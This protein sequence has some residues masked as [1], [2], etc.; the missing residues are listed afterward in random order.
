MSN[1]P[2]LDSAIATFEGFGKPGTIAT[3]QNNPGDLQYGP[4]AVAHGAS[5]P[6]ATATGASA[7][8]AIF[9]TVTQGQAAQDALVTQYA[10]QD[11]TVGGLIDK[12]SGV[13]GNTP[14]QDFVVGK[15]PAGTTAATPV[16]SLATP[17]STNP[18]TD[19]LGAAAAKLATILSPVVG[20]PGTATAALSP[21]P[22]INAT[23]SLWGFP[24][25]RVAAGIAGLIFIAGGIFMLKPTQNIIASAGKIATV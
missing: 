10:A 2:A 16:S 25:G 14:Y 3:N 24:V 17:A 22:A 6:G 18:L 5:G 11:Y 1:F 8:T 19:T 12:W 23:S 7:P 9:P 4:F 20:A 15:L 21:N 13:Q